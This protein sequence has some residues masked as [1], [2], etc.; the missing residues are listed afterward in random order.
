M[1]FI[2]RLENIQD[3][4]DTS[5]GPSTEK[6]KT[7]GNRRDK[8]W[9]TYDEALINAVQTKQCLWDIKSK[10]QER[11]PVAVEEAWRAVVKQVNGKVF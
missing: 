4:T 5:C 7:P 3:S 1:F 8:N 11:S 9:A 6:K 10:I 2:A